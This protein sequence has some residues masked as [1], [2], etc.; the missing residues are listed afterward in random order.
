MPGPHGVSQARAYQP[1]GRYPE[2]QQGQ[3]EVRGHLRDK[4]GRRARCW[5]AAVS[6]QHTA[7]LEPI[8]GDEHSDLSPLTRGMPQGGTCTG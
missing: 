2:S 8:E 4:M 7:P 3:A 5:Y 6:N 1:S